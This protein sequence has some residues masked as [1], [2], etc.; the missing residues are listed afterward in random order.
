MPDK[1][2]LFDWVKRF[3]LHV[4]TGALAVAVHY[5]IMAVAMGIGVG[6]LGAS[7]LGFSVGAATRFFTAYFHV[8]APSDNVRDTVPRFLLA[9]GAQFV[10]NSVLLSGLIGVGL[11]V[12][13]AQITTTILMT[14]LNYVVYRLWVFR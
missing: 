11:A 7:S 8:F 6:P 10:L 13:W 12:W 3:V 1:D 2:L 9:L 4:A 14:F 5:T